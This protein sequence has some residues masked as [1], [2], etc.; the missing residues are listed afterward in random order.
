M[1]AHRVSHLK[2]TWHFNVANWK[3]SSRKRRL[4]DESLNDRIRVSSFFLQDSPV[5]DLIRLDSANSNDDFDPLLARSSEFPNAKQM[6]QSLHLPEMGEGLSNP[7]YPYF[8]PPSRKTNEKSK[9]SDNVGDM[10][11][12]QAYGI[13]FNKFSLS[14][15]D[16]S[17]AMSTAACN[18]GDNS[19]N[20]TMD[21][22]G[23]TLNAPAIK[24]QNNWTKF[25]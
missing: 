18:R 12:L 21:A 14:N 11:L 24:S 25:E 5:P 15:G 4:A 3:L 8:Q 22:F 9:I 1:H 16:D 6:T 23:L 13:D 10:D 20:D 19:I 2:N 7:L 17:P